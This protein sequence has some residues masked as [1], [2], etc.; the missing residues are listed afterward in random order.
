MV[1]IATSVLNRVG[2]VV[3]VDGVDVVEVVGGAEGPYSTVVA[4]IFTLLIAQS[5]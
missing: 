1:K 3:D 2:R 5:S 4:H